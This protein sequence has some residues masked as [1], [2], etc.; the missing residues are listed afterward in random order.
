[1]RLV[2]FACLFFFFFS[3]ANSVYSDFVFNS[4]KL[5]VGEMFLPTTPKNFTLKAGEVNPD[6]TFLLLAPDPSHVL[7][8]SL[9]AYYSSQDYY[10][11]VEFTSYS[12][13]DDMDAVSA[14]KRIEYSESA[15]FFGLLNVTLF[16]KEADGRIIRFSVVAANAD[17]LAAS[18]PEL[19][20][21][22]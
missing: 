3:L 19:Q 2:F 18:F 22:E 11:G 8:F 9:N 14:K 16:P 5:H 20:A 21:S 17:L 4:P 13:L 1:M 10:D 6:L 12:W 7:R 15:I